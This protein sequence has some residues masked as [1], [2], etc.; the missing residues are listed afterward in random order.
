MT[1]RARLDDGGQSQVTLRVANVLSYVVFKDATRDGPSAYASFRTIPD[2][3]DEQAR[4]RR[5][6]VVTVRA[7]LGGFREGS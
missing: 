5:E 3:E 2:D 4:L 6:A 7:S 1:S